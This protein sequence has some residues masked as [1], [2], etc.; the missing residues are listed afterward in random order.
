[1]KMKPAEKTLTPD[2]ILQVG[3]GFFSS[4]A[5]LAAVQLGLFSELSGDSLSGDELGQRVGLTHRSRTDLFDGLVA[6]GFLQREGDGESGLY[7][8]SAEAELFLVR[9]SPHYIGG[10]LEMAAARLYP[11]WSDLDKAL[12]TGKPQNEVKNTGKSIFEELYAD[13]EKLELFL[14]GMR[15]ISAGSFAALAEKFDFSQYETLCDIGGATGQLCISVASNHPN[16][17]C[18]SFDLPPVKPISQKYI[19]D[20]GLS[21]RIEP[22]D[23]NFFEDELPKADVITM[24]MILHDWNLENKKIL[25]KKAYDALPTRGAFIVI[26]NLI[27][28][29]RR[30]NVFGFMMSL[31]MLVEF[32]D[33]FDFS[34][35]DFEG[36]CRE[37]G[38][39][40]FDKIHL[41][42]PC[43]AAIAYK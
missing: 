19:D 8:N 5:L 33:A 37:I 12:K 16:I 39:Q 6:L 14:E 24:G 2:G 1:M 31:N 7:S 25:I 41:A 20:S 18:R 11:F 4:R 23:G 35:A 38:F 10:I 21:D 3:F 22:V 9:S 26:E 29:A 13:P 42:G 40:K 17:R 27:D 32:G 28:D 34:A 43:S 30:E 36:W 15:G